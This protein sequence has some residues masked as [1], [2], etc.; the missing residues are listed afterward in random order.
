MTSPALFATLRSTPPL[1][2]PLD[3]VRPV[4]SSLLPM[5]R[6]ISPLPPG[7]P[8]T[9]LLEAPQSFSTVTSTELAARH[10]DLTPPALS[11]LLNDYEQEDRVLTS[12][13]EEWELEGFA[14]EV[15]RMLQEGDVGR[16]VEDVGEGEDEEMVVE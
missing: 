11:L 7:H 2:A 13:L 8:P 1:R 12:L 10:S 9:L 5:L 3:P 4:S 15:V 16:E 6:L 14:K